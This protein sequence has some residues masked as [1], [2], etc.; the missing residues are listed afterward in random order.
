MGSS[1]EADLFLPE[2]LQT[3]Y[4]PSGHRSH[5]A[6]VQSEGGQG[7]RLSGEREAELFYGSTGVCRGVVVGSEGGAK[8]RCIIGAAGISRGGC[9]IAG[10]VIE[11][12][13]A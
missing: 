2:N 6:E 10:A 11:G 5:V 4:V 1:F 12:T 9:G 3:P 13:E 7:L 8:E